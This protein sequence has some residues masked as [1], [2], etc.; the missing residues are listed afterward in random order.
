MK[1]YVGRVFI[2]IVLIYTL[3]IIEESVR[4]SNNSL[5][6]P[7]IIL[8][9]SYSGDIGDVTYRSLGFTLKTDYA[10][11]ND[12]NDRVYPISQEFWLFDIFLIWG[13]I[14]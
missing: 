9:E 8:D 12:S 10:K 5:A 13:W 3:F 14:S 4:L 7:L 6:E 2:V 1:K 11:F